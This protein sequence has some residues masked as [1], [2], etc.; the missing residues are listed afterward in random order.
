MIIEYFDEFGKDNV[1][2]L[3]KHVKGYEKYI[4]EHH[5]PQSK[6]YDAVEAYVDTLPVV[7]KTKKNY[8]YGLRKYIE[9]ISRNYW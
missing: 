4:K 3:P 1:R 8:R 5:I 7:T 2:V 6:V 9:E